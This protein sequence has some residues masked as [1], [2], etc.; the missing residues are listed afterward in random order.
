MY[1]NC[2]AVIIPTLV[3]PHTFPLYEAFYFKKPV[4][5][6]SKVLDDELKDKVIGL[7][8]DNINDLD[9]A[10]IKIKDQVF[11]ENLTETNYK[12]F[13]KTFDQENMIKM[14]GNILKNSLIK[15]E[16]N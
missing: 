7:D 15:N 5:Y 14:L 10:L 16:I 2:S 1:E 11:I 12:Y 3:A 13:K 4:I 6:N 8:V 9:N